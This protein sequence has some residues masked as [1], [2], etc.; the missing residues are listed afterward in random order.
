MPSNTNEITIERTFNA[1]RALVW[2]AWTEPEHFMK[3]WGPK[4]FTCPIAQT[5]L[6]VGGRFFWAMRWPDGRTNYN[7][8]EFLVVDPITTFTFTSN[9]ADEHGNVVPASHYGI[10]GD[11]PS[12]A[13]ITVTLTEHGDRTKMTLR[14]VGIPDGQFQDMTRMGWNQSFD[15][16]SASLS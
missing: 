16:L 5:D 3:W 2:R 12:L 9:F 15:K 8:G 6:R 14:H 10:P 13:T 1:P 4:D 11:V 7:T